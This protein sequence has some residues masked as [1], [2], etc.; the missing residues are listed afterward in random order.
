MLKTWQATRGHELQLG[1]ATL[2]K[3][4]LQL[5]VSGWEHTDF[6][7]QSWNNSR[8]VAITSSEPAPTFVLMW[9]KISRVGISCECNVHLIKSKS[10][11]LSMLLTASHWHVHTWL[12]YIFLYLPIRQHHCT[13]LPITSQ[14][15]VTQISYQGLAVAKKN[16]R[17]G[18]VCVCVSS[19]VQCEDLHGA[20]VPS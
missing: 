10:H 11:W 20:V 12:Q 8:T 7:L 6:N 19:E 16:C 1:R 17:T 14:S 3:A 2:I 18:Q 15:S 4:D 13:G 5:L 9:A